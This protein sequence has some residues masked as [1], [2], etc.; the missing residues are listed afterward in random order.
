MSRRVRAALLQ[1]ALVVA[2]LAVVGAVAGVVWEGVWTAPVGFVVQNKWYLEPSGPDYE[3]SGTGWYV[4]VALLAGAV[5]AGAMAWFL[6]RRELTTLVAVAVGSV[7]AG[8]VM[9]K[10]GHALG[11][12]DPQLLAAGQPDLTQ[13]PSSLLVAGGSA[14]T[15]FPIG[16]LVALVFVFLVSPGRRQRA[17]DPSLAG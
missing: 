5:S 14:Y 17:V 16:A 12:A 11:P 8:W 4:V 9:F 6:P 13:I 10:V 3:F 1:A 2:L 15:A 7:V